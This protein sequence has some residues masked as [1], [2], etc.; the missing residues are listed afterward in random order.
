MAAIKP[1]ANRK[2]VV[3]PSDGN[4]PFKYRDGTANV[5]A[6]LVSGNLAGRSKKGGCK[7]CG[8]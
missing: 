7:G 4:S 3:K 6:V 8:K 1:L 5:S 2:N